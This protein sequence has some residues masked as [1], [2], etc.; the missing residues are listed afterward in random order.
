MIIYGNTKRQMKKIIEKNRHIFKIKSCEFF[1]LRQLRLLLL[2]ACNGQKKVAKELTERKKTPKN[3]ERAEWI[4]NRIS[5]CR[6]SS[7]TRARYIHCSSI[8]ISVAF[9]WTINVHER[10][11]AFPNKQCAY[12]KQ[13]TTKTRNIHR[14]RRSR[15]RKKTTELIAIYTSD[16]KKPTG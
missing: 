3:S 5:S 10:E 8:L 9:S 1:S 7:R 16:K 4:K 13:W 14:T 2:Y 15:S 11:R 6:K 12:G